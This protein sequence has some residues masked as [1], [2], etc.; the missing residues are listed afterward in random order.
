MPFR[1]PPAAGGARLLDGVLMPL[2]GAGVAAESAEVSAAGV[3]SMTWATGVS[4][5]E[6]DDL[7][8]GSTLWGNLA[9]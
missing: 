8:D 4:D 5:D 7:A 1:F 2:A 3:G 6:V 9:S